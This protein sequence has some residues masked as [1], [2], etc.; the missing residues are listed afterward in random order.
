MI[1]LEVP[2]MLLSTSGF[3]TVDFDDRDML[4]FSSKLEDKMLITLFLATATKSPLILH[5]TV[6]CNEMMLNHINNKKWL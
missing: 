5:S 2:F 4:S 6:H 1:A 3:P